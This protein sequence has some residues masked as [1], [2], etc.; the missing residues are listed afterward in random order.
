MAAQAQAA[1]NSRK[2]TVNRLRL[3]ETLKQNREDHVRKFHEAIDGYIE[4]AIDSVNKGYDEEMVAA[5][6]RHEKMLKQIAEFDPAHPE[7]T[8]SY[9]RF[10]ESSGVSVPVPANYS[11]M[12]KTAID[13]MEWDTREEVELTYA[14]FQC[15]IQ[16]EWEWK[17]EFEAIRSTYM[18]AKKMA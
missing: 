17:E 9:W 14:E 10:T 6:K 7:K 8:P 5:K 18:M 1:L 12:Y 2:V 15:F 16:D 3:I 4:T 11:E 13:M